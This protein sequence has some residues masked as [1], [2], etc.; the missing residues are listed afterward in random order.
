MVVHGKHFL[1]H[2]LVKTFAGLVHDQINYCARF[3]VIQ[4]FLY[5][6]GAA[7][8]VDKV[9]EAHARNVPFAQN[10]EDF[11]NFH[12][13]ALVDGEAQADLDAFFLA[14]FK[15]FQ[16]AAVGTGYAPEAIVDF[17]AAVE[18]D[19]HIREADFF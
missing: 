16:G 17:F 18:R 14:I 4:V 2:P 12:C 19:A 10:I 7:S 11:G 3:G 15:P 9:I 5:Q 6:F 1:G 8:G 13:V